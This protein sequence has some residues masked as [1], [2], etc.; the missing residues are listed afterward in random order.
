METHGRSQV[1]AAIGPLVASLDGST[2]ELEP[3]QDL[4]VCKRKVDT[5][6]DST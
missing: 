4:E 1:S 2:G 5:M 6:N 3:K